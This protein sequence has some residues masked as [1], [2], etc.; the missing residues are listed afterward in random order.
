MTSLT[1][2]QRNAS[3]ITTDEK[4]VTI[5]DLLGEPLVLAF[6]PAAFT[7]TC[8]TEMC[9]LRDS[10]VRFNAVQ[11]QVY[12]ISIDTPFALEA[13]GQQNGLTFPLLSD[14]NR[15]ATRAF[16]IV[17]SDLSGVHDVSKRAVF[18][19]DKNGAIVYRWVGKTLGVEPPYDEV[20]AAVEGLS[21]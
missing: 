18:V 15:A 5:G 13:F 21:R 10:L 16:D 12:G 19:V 8:T 14:A 9:T 3:L 7:S 17:W 6:F 20:I 4:P 2:E 1:P 11:A